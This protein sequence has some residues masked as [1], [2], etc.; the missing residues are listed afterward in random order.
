MMKINQ[1]P[2]FD[3]AF[4]QYNAN[5]PQLVLKIDYEKI[6]A[7]GINIQD[8]YTALSSQF[9]TYYVNDFNLYGR[10]FRVMMS[11]DEQYRTDI[12]SMDKVYV[13][14]RYGTS[15][16]LSSLISVES[17]TGPYDITRFNMYKSIQIIASPAKGQST[18][19]A[20]ASR[21]KALQDFHS[22]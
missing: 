7:Q 13:K 5:T 16:P 9:G 17:T 2:K 6:L 3:Y 22:G 8:V 20:I 4:T 21:S 18:G 11:A 15:S 14:T 1:N 19:D 10:V 12:N